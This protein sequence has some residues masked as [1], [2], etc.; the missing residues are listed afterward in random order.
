MSF[1]RLLLVIPI[2]GVVAPSA[3]AQSSGQRT[4]IEAFRD[5]LDRSTDSL[6][7]ARLETRLVESVRRDRRNTMDHLRL[8]FLALR[9]GDLG[10]QRYYEDA[11]AEFQ[12]ATRMAPSWPYGWYGLGLAEY[13]IATVRQVREAAALKRPFQRAQMALARAISLDPRMAELLEGEAFAA[14]RRQPA[15]G[16]VVLD[17]V[18]QATQVRGA[19]PMLLAPLGRLERE[20]GEPEAALKA[21]EGFLPRAGRARAM[22]LLEIARTRFMLDRA[23]GAGPY[24]EGA[25]IDD[26]VAV[27]AYRRDIALIAADPELGVYDLATG[28]ARAAF[29]KTFW[30]LRDASALRSEGERLQEHYRRVY[31][32]R[33]IYPGIIPV[34]GRDPSLRIALIEP[35]VDDRGAI[36]IRHGEPDDRVQMSTLGVEPNES[37]RYSSSE[38]DQV[39]H[40]VARHEPDVY[41]LVESLFDVA[42]LPDLAP[43]DVNGGL[44]LGQERLLRSR[45]PLSPFYGRAGRR[46]EENSRDFRLAERALSRASLTAA[47]TSDSYRHRFA[48][49]LAARLDMVV[50]EADSS[51]ALLNIAYAVPFDSLGAAWLAQGLEYPLHLRLLVFD[52]HG[53]PLAGVDSTVRPLT[54]IDGEE[55]W[56]SGSVAVPVPVG[57]FRM[58]LRLQ[59]GPDVGSEPPVRSLE[60]VPVA[61][62]AIGLSDLALGDPSG[63][64]PVAMPRGGPVALN[65][66]GRFRRGEPVE[67][68]YQVSAPSGIPLVSQ[69]TLIRTDEQAGVIRSD[70]YQEAS[71]DWPKIIRHS[72]DVRKLKPG[73]YR[74][75]VTLTDGRGGLARRWKEFTVT[76]AK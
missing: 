65:P 55:R 71:A 34:P 70:R 69:V 2:F 22:T 68:A 64:W 26:S 23:D 45:E 63:R 9:Q 35:P 30:R 13:G 39:L 60:I 36:Y 46:A 27:Q 49:S 56:L 7:L 3:S 42:D 58:R 44:V 4:I 57:R 43:A 21:F 28:P 20:F 61:P 51:R 29:L 14:R 8:G 17:A 38:G 74:L 11:A 62:S 25:A 24:Y 47:T 16:S 72:I 54:L 5:S 41:R 12:W 48:R 67:L 15:R 73:P 75:E 37:W 10:V 66:L 59:D 32:A 1:H 52:P 6:A 31:L 18:R 76:D 19:N 53:E 50:L 40:F 33:R